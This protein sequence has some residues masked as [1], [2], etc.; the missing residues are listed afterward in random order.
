[1]IKFDAH[2][3]PLS[4]YT[5]D[6]TC[7]SVL[8]IGVTHYISVDNHQDVLMSLFPVFNF[9]CVHDNFGNDKLVRKI[10]IVF[11]VNYFHQ[12]YSGAMLNIF[13]GGQAPN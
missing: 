6:M 7:H 11:L 1:M 12:K 3:G 13:G 8:L 10:S 5:M 2:L 9:L 4:S